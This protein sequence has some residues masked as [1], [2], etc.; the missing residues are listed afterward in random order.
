VAHILREKGFDAVVINGGLNAWKKA[1]LPIEPVP[2]D[3]IVHL[4][5]FARQPQPAGKA[6]ALR[7]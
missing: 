4:P 6:R 7:F 3:D 5:S 1:G 2:P